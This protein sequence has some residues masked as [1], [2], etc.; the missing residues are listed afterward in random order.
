VRTINALETGALSDLVD[1]IFSEPLV[2]CNIA[3]VETEESDN[4]SSEKDES[5]ECTEETPTVVSLWT[6][7]TCGLPLSGF[8]LAFLN[9]TVTGVSYG[10]FLGYMGLDSNV[11]MSVTSLMQLPQVLL[12]PLGVMNDCIPILG[13]NRKPYLLAAWL[14]C[15]GALLTMSTRPLPAPYYCQHPDGSYDTLSPPCNPDIHAMKN[16]YVIPMFSLVAGIQLGCV[17]GE[18]LLLEYSQAEAPECRGKMKA[19]FTMVT[20][21]GSLT[22]SAVIGL[23]MNRKEYLGTFDW[24]LSFSGLM[25]LCFAIVA[26]MLPICVRCVHES[27]KVER[28]SFR[29][30]VGNSWSLIQSKCLASVLLYAFITQFLSQ[31][32]TTARPL[33]RCIWAE[34]K[35]L[36]AQLFQMGG[37][38][39]M[40][41][42]VWIYK[43]YFL[44]SCWRRSIFV[45]ILTVT[46]M[47]S[48]PSFFAVFGVIRNQYFFLGDE[49]A[50]T[51]PTAALGL[52][53]N[54]IVIELSEPGQ[55]GLCYGLVGTVMHSSQPVSTAVSNQVS[56]LF[57]PSLS[58]PEN[59]AMDAPSF[60][61]TVAWSYVFTY[62]ASL[63]GACALP[64]IPRQK[65]DAQR[66]KLEWSSSTL[67][68]ALV[69]G[70]P[71]LSLPYGITVLVLTSQP[72]TACLR[73][74]GGQG[75]ENPF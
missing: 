71:A 72:D 16:W 35:V 75:C 9:A 40:I 3:D 37:M 31:L 34:V 65:A 43:V 59:Y 6:V 25:I 50:S 53:L 14:I 8:F 70:V 32:T 7:A 74:I 49:M 23:F 38:V 22:S 17:A 63:L 5:Q 57:T 66:R 42:V 33:V 20:M 18:G 11:M 62:G 44:Q 30:H 27:K 48:I 67:M 55:E 69:L 46:L 39:M 68:T 29:T 26:C 12:L 36:Q 58:K 13:Y 24:G 64:L 15:G 45:A 52:I 73:W 54:L 61:T 10:F 1:Y 28:P 51:V 56:S 41:L 21:A 4:A 19:E 60:R 47:D 2:E